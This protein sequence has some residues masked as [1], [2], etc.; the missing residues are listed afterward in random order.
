MVHDARGIAL[1]PR[2]GPQPV[3]MQCDAGQNILLLYEIPALIDR[4]AL[5]PQATT[6]SGSIQEWLM[7]DSEIK[8]LRFHTDC[9]YGSKT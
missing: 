3:F 4:L 2:S 1:R 8:H 7:S 5:R 9:V 6:F